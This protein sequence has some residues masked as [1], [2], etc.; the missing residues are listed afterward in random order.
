[1]FPCPRRQERISGILA[2]ARETRS[3]SALAI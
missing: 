2:L 3:G 1:M